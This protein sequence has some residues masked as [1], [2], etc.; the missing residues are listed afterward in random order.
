M[1]QA[2][3]NP[4][5]Q[6]AH[7]ARRRAA[8]IASAQHTL[9]ESG[10]DASIEKFAAAAGVSIATLYKHF[11]SKDGLLV[12]AVVDMQQ[13]WEAW[14]AEVVSVLPTETEQF[15]AAGRLALRSHELNPEFASIG[16]GILRVTPIDLG[17]LASDL[18]V[19]VD[20]LV[21]EGAIRT[22]QVDRRTRLYVACLVDEFMRQGALRKPNADEA[23]SVVEIALTLLGFTQARARKLVSAPLPPLADL[24]H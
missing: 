3:A 20:S 9:A 23:D 22:D 6:S 1:T 12:A 10:P 13:R 5:R 7:L 14:M 15:V 2:P 11:D 18:S 21:A 17:V 19:R 24:P 4:S 16:L 8:L